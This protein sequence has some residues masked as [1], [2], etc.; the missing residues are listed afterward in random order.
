VVV[1]L[2][3]GGLVYSLYEITGF[4]LSFLSL[5]CLILS[6]SG[7]WLALLS[8]GLTCD[9]GRFG[10]IILLSHNSSNGICC[11]LAGWASGPL[12][13][14]G[15]YKLHFLLLLVL[16]MRVYY[17]M[18]HCMLWLVCFVSIMGPA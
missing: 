12:P 13:E 8:L 14:R 18:G 15:V 16:V 3:I 7:W 2:A 6:S 11:L 10:I 4:C 9:I 1:S 5:A 17:Y